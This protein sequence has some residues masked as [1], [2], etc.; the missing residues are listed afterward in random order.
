MI[1]EKSNTGNLW[2]SFCKDF[3]NNQLTNIWLEVVEKIG[4]NFLSLRQ[5]DQDNYIVTPPDWNNTMELMS[6]EGIS[7]ADAM[8]LNM[9]QSS[10]F[11]AILSSDADIGFAVT[12]MNRP[13]KIC[14]LPDDIV[15]FI[16]IA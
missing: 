7:S 13:D 9:Y 4:L 8:I 1:C 10:K 14:V 3:I 2:F 11:N 12:N 5:N 15:K 6:R 16:K